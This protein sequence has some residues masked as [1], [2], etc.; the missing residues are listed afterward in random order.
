MVS[1]S[2]GWGQVA[3]A[4]DQTLFVLGENCSSLLLHLSLEKA[5]SLVLWAPNGEFL[6]VGDVIGRVH[7]IHVAS[8]RLLT[9][10]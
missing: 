3:V 10:R 8:N 5:V 4:L 2:A 6:M 7:Y 9:T 1:A